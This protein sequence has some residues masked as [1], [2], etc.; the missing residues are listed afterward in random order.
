MRRN[1]V[2]LGVG[3]AFAL[4]WLWMDRAGA[5]GLAAEMESALAGSKYVYIASTRKDGSLGKPAEIWFMY[6]GGAVWVA[7]PATTWR[8]QRIRAGRPAAKIWV[9]KPDGPS[10]TARGSFVHDAEV[11]RAM[12]ETFAKKYPEGWGQY[13]KVFGEEL[14]SGKRLMI[15]YEPAD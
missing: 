13:E 8:A 14:G 12:F 9:G 5:A 11:Q 4:S 3:L 6:H 15:K 2:L 10:F 1:I 7:S